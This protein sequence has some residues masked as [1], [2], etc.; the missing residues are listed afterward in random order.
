MKKTPDD[1]SSTQKPERAREIRSAQDFLD[2]LAGDNKK[3]LLEFTKLFEARVASRIT[4]R[5][6]SLSTMIRRHLMATYRIATGVDVKSIRDTRA[7]RGVNAPSPEEMEFDREYAKRRTPETFALDYLYLAEA[8]H[9]VT[10]SRTAVGDICQGKLDDT[11]NQQVLDIVDQLIAILNKLSLQEQFR[12]QGTSESALG[13]FDL[14]STSASID[15]VCMLLVTNLQ[16]TKNEIMKKIVKEQTRK[17]GANETSTL[18]TTEIKTI[19]DLLKIIF[20]ICLSHMPRL[21]K[22]SPT[23][24]VVPYTLET[25]IATW[26]GDYLRVLEL[27]LGTILKAMEAKPGLFVAEIMREHALP[28]PPA[29]EVSTTTPEGSTN[30]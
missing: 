20:K 6:P 18:T 4:E 30:K 16:T 15:L 22:S 27:S 23:P 9:I 10:A 17:A 12:G 28:K 8:I 7:L 26:S 19:M 14:Y 21:R 1:G 24:T 11:S 13:K 2:I 29:I 5:L 3:E 25:H